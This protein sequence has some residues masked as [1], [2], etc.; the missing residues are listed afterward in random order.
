MI[1]GRGSNLQAALSLQHEL[2]FRLVISS[3]S[4]AAG[5]ARARREGVPTLVMDC[6]LGISEWLR[7]DLELKRRNIDCIFLLGFMRL[8]PPQFVDRWAHQIFNLHPSLL[9]L[10]P[11]KNAIE[12]SFSDGSPMGVTVHKVT[13]EMDAGPI[14]LQKEIPLHEVDG[15]LKSGLQKISFQISCLEQAMV[16]KVLLCS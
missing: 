16:R 15:K 12:K 8:L 11:G 6:S 1:S 7:I 2:N 14:V 4:D 5:L 10:H 3:R 9:P 13:A